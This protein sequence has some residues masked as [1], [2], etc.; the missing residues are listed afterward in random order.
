[1]V[2][3]S[4]LGLW[5]F[6]RPVLVL[7]QASWRWKTGLDWTGPLNTRSG[8]GRDW[9]CHSVAQYW[10][11]ELL[12]EEVELFPCWLHWGRPAEE[13]ILIW[14]YVMKLDQIAECLVAFSCWPDC[15]HSARLEYYGNQDCQAS[16]GFDKH[17]PDG[18]A[19]FVDICIKIY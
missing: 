1:M 4:L 10:W 9:T 2:W 15:H 16:K 13:V 14:P 19:S 7:V 18:D 6:Q 11:L 12:E 5:D 3:S 17:V 8:Q